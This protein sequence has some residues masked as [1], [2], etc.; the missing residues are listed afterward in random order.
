[1]LM[2]LRVSLE[3]LTQDSA[4]L[5]PSCA[6][7][8]RLSRVQIFVTPWTEAF[9]AALS[10][11][12][13]RQEYWSGLPCPP[14]G[15]LSNPGIKPACL[16]SPELAGGFFI[17]RATWEAQLPVELVPKK[18]KKKGSVAEEGEG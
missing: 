11:G 13:S 14:P 15:D 17:T 7:R 2:G 16:R 1:M 5:L 9:Q 12:F 6:A 10:T 4:R 8:C 3:S 18:K